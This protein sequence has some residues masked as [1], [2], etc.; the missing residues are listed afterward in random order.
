[1]VDRRLAA[2]SQIYRAVKVQRLG[3]EK[4]HLPLTLQVMPASP[5]KLGASKAHY[6]PAGVPECGPNRRL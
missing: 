6:H 2:G 5:R 3:Q 1:M 4:S